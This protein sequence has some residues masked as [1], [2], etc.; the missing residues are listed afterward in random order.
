MRN[1]AGFTGENYAKGRNFVWQAMWVATSSLIFERSWCPAALRVVI[2]RSFGAKIGKGVLIRRHV[3]VHWPWKLTIADNVWIGVEAWILNLEHVEI[4]SNV[5]I[6]QGAFLCTGSHD[7][8]SPTF[9][10][11]NAPISVGDG[12]WIAARATVLRGVTI[13]RE[14]VVGATALVPKSVPDGARVYAP[15]ATVVFKENQ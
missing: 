10:F 5:C 8:R 6:S 14:A 1:L 7:S 3:K 4:G 13:G 12:A 9:E 11:D 15:A 2:L